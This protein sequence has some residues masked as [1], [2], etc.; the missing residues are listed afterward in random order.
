[1]SE[2]LELIEYT[3][4]EEGIEVACPHMDSVGILHSLK[5]LHKDQQA[6]VEA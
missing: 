3:D 1:M 5:E 4:S 6:V 2:A